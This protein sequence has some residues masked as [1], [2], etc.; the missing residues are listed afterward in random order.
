MIAEHFNICEKR[1][2]QPGA[3]FLVCPAQS[4][5]KAP[6]P[7]QIYR[8][9]EGFSRQGAGLLLQTALDNVPPLHK[10]FLFHK[11]RVTGVGHVL[12]DH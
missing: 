7:F 1:G 5:E 8:E 4:L 9:V 12:Y 3:F 10:T 11:V 2:D 6:F